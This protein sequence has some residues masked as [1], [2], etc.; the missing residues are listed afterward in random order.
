M[1]CFALLCSALLRSALLS[2]PRCS[3]PG[4][5]SLLCFSLLCF[6]T[7]ELSLKRTAIITIPYTQD[8][9][10]LCGVSLLPLLLPSGA[11][12]EDRAFFA[13]RA[14]DAEY[15]SNMGNTGTFMLR[16]GKWKLITYGTALPEIFGPDYTDQLFD[17]DADANELDDVSYTRAC[18]RGRA[19]SGESM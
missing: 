18:A 12:E 17:L 9:A 15:H 2:S 19:Y 7:D 3:S 6:C 8:F 10:P 4:C 14:V 5:S 11:D 1:W 13:D 16:S